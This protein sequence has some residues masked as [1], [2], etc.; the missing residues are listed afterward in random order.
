MIVMGPVNR[1]LCHFLKG[2]IDP[3]DISSR[4]LTVLAHSD[5]IEGPAKI[6]HMKFEMRFT[7]VRAIKVIF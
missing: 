4:S 3:C 7:H 2:Q 1:G 5:T 6:I